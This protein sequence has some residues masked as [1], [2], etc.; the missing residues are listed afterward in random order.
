MR[1]LYARLT[2]NKSIQT[3]ATEPDCEKET[4]LCDIR[5]L[6]GINQE[7]TN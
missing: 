5:Y 1:Q 3:G 2:H 7:Q 6:N 4:V